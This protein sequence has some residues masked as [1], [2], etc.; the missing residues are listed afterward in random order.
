MGEHEISSPACR[1][2]AGQGAV[3]TSAHT[4]APLREGPPCPTRDFHPTR[5]RRL[6]SSAVVCTAVSLGTL[7]LT[8]PSAFAVAAPPPG[9]DSQVVDGNAFLTNGVIEIGSRPNGSYGSDIDAPDG[10]HPL[11]EGNNHV[12]FRSDRDKDGWGV[13]TDDGDFF[14]PGSPYEGWGLQVG[15]AGATNW[16]FDEST[17]IAGAYAGPTSTATSSAVTWQSDAATDGVTVKQED[18]VPAG[19]QYL[20]TRITLTNTTGAALNDIYYVR[21]VDPDNCQTRTDPVCDSDGDGVADTAGEYGTSNTVQQQQTAGDSTAVVSADQ[22]DGSYIDL[23]SSAAGSIVA[24]GTQGDFCTDPSGLQGFYAGTTVGDGCPI[25]TTKGDRVFT[26]DLIYLVVKT[27]SL[28]PGASRTFLTRYVL[29]QNA[30]DPAPAPPVVHKPTKGEV[31][32]KAIAK[33]MRHSRVP[34]VCKV[35]SGLL[36]RC[37]VR[38]TAVVNGH[39]VLLGHQVRTFTHHQ[40][41]RATLHVSLNRRGRALVNRVGGVR[42]TATATI[43]AKDSSRAAV[44]RDSGRLLP[45]HGVAA[46]TVHFKSDSPKVSAAARHRLSNL[47]SRLGHVRTL[48][49][50]AYT[51]NQGSKAFN[52][53]LSQK[54]A[55]NVH[56]ALHPRASVRVH[57]LSYG[58]SHPVRSNKTARGRAANRRATV[59]VSY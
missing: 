16:N 50:R 52:R 14:T 34:A 5:R 25:S 46:L 31:H 22:T 40:V 10:Y 35:T 49:I 21:A 43:R 33:V 30:A 59:R 8:A 45:R 57:T 32:I 55:R 24:T 7:G 11:S 41:R 39:R 37:T 15:N 1:S 27:P 56:A 3:R 53:R 9:H 26:D 19:A 58:E 18:I 42:V 29:K 2:P 13:G 4:H 48:T 6:V 51:D 54:R 17:S 44:R 47:R 23:R 38:L 20:N 12:G 28:A 36:T